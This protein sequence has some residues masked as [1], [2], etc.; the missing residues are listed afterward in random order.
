MW[1]LDGLEALADVECQQQVR[2]EGRPRRG[3]MLYDLTMAVNALDDV[4]AL[5]HPEEEIGAIFR[6]AWEA[7]AMRRL[8]RLLVPLIE[9]LGESPDAAYVQ[10]P[11]W[12]AVV[13]AATAALST[14]RACAPSR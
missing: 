13:A 10:S 6:T 2:V 1:A 11:E 4:R 8:A 14:M 5:D 7:E 12:P 3:G 9:R